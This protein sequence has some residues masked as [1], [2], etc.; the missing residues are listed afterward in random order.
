[1]ARTIQPAHRNGFRVSLKQIAEATG[2]SLMTVSR[3]LRG[4]PDIAAET[5]EQILS[6]ASKLGYRPNLLVRGLQT[7]RSGN[8]ALLVSPEGDFGSGIVRGAHDELV[9]QQYLPILHWKWAQAGETTEAAELGVI[10][11]VLDRRVE[12]IIFFPQDDSVPD[13]YFREVWQRGVPLLTVDRRLARTKADFVGTDDLA[14]A[15]M[16]AEHLLA[17]GHRHVA[18]LA[19]HAKYGTHADR[20]TGFEA[21]IAK[22]RGCCRTVEVPGADAVGPLTEKLLLSDPRPTAI[23]L[24]ADFQAPAVYQTAAKLGLRIPDDLSVVGFADLAFAKYLAPPLTTVRQDP[25]GIGRE[26]ARVIVERCSRTLKDKE[27]VQLRLMPE[28]IVRDSTAK[29][30]G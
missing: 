13:L 26:A 20:R 15:R 18:H 3:A 29:V 6:V 11:R 12:G 5:R 23:F 14:G 16:A 30:R 25:Y 28:L 2:C 19:G 1:M 22:G 4:R 9:R 10:H 27:P 24:T 21:A 7:G 17:L 8:I